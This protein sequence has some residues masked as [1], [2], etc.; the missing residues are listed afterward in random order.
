MS[1]TDPLLSIPVGIVF[2]IGGVW[3][4]IAPGDFPRYMGWARTL[5]RFLDDRTVSL[6]LRVCGVVAGGAS[7]WLVLHATL[8]LLST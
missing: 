2:A 7:T 5:D 1:H 8:A 3:L 6:I 4:A